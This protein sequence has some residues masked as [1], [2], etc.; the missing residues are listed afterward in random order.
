VKKII[1]LSL[2]LLLVF[3]MLLPSVSIAGSIPNERLYP[4]LVDNA[5]LL[6]S[7]E[8]SKLLDKLDQISEKQDLD[9]VVVTVDSLEGYSPSEYADDFYDYNGYGMGPGHDGILLLISMEERDWAITTYGFAIT[10]FTD[11]GLDRIIEEIIPHLSDG[12]YYKAFD[13]FGDLADEYTRAARNGRAYDVGN[14]PKKPPSPLLIPIS[15]LI[16]AII[17]FLITGFMK[18]QLKTVRMQ[19]SATSYVRQNSL[20]LVASRDIYLYN[21]ITRRARPKKSE[22]S[23]GGSTTHRSSSGRSHGGKS[24]KF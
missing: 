6:D 4:R 7:E 3:A 2:V 20:N 21:V 24:G 15:L 8:E 5:F 17:S 11:A 22:S 1:T 16:G 14:L 18:S 19:K 12:N 9:V 23:R 10:A 13:R